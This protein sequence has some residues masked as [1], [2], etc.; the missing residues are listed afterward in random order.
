MKI[1]GLSIIALICLV[2]VLTID[3]SSFKIP[4]I[5]VGTANKSENLKHTLS[6][7]YLAS[8]IF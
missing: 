4:E 7:S 1:K 6:I 3:L 5:I 2:I 8:Y